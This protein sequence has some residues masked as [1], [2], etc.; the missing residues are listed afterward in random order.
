MRSANCALGDRDAGDDRADTAG[1]FSE[2]PDEFAASACFCEMPAY[3]TNTGMRGPKRVRRTVGIKVTR[4]IR[5]RIR[6]GR[7]SRSPAG[8]HAGADI[9]DGRRLKP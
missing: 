1:L 2:I 5:S 9:R 7:S 6:A 8:R 3:F 4:C